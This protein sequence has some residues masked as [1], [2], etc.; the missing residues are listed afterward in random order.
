MDYYWRVEPGVEF[1]CDIKHTD[2]FRYMRG[3]LLRSDL[4]S[5]APTDMMPAD[6]NKRYGFTLTM[7]EAGNTIP[8]LWVSCL[9]WGRG[10]VRALERVGCW[11]VS[12]ELRC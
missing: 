11:W 8:T 5:T 10:A 6:N 1:M 7:T 12:K 9:R 4:S 3:E 2:P